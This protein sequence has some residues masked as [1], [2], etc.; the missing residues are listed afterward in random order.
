MLPQSLGNR[1]FSWG[2]QQQRRLPTTVPWQPAS[3]LLCRVL[4]EEGEP[5]PALVSARPVWLTPRG[6][7][8]RANTDF[9]VP[10]RNVGR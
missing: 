5:G 1:Q 8:A 7:G 6:D 3:A 9:S 4:P 2:W 10:V